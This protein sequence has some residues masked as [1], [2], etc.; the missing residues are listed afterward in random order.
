MGQL[1]ASMSF[2]SLSW[3]SSCTHC[4]SAC[5]SSLG[6]VCASSDCQQSTAA[7]VPLRQHLIDEGSRTAPRMGLML[8]E[9]TPRSK[10]P[11]F[12]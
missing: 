12:S 5:I 8:P 6:F 10:D 4:R 11:D 1:E 3:Y 7:Q 2:C 9:Q